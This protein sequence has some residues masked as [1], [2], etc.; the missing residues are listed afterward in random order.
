MVCELSGVFQIYKFHI[1]KDRRC[2]FS[3]C[4]KRAELCSQKCQMG[5]RMGNWN[6]VWLNVS[7]RFINAQLI[8]EILHRD[9]LNDDVEFGLE[10]VRCEVNYESFNILF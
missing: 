1:N 2:I 6:G 7:L 9:S 10:I 3:I 4:V 5:L 8:P